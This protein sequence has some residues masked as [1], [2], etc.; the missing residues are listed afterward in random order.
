MT[1]TYAQP[2]P[3]LP[4]PATAT[5]TT[6][7]GGSTRRLTGLSI[8]L[9]CRDAESEVAGAIRSLAAGAAA[10]SAEYEIVVVDDGSRDGTAGRVAAFV[11]ATGP[12]RLLVHSHP[13]G[14]GAAL[15]TGLG[16]ARMPW[17]LLASAHEA[18]ADGD[19]PGFAALTSSAELVAGRRVSRRDRGSRRPAVAVW[20]ALMRALFHL[21]VHDVDCAFKLV[22]RDRLAGV[23][24]RASGPVVAAE[25]VIRCRAAGARVAEYP[26]VP[27]PLGAQGRLHAGAVVRALV[28]TARRQ[29][30]LRRLARDG[31]RRLAP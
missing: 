10:T 18:L 16:A 15:R 11:G 12:V 4:R 30:E 28:E 26:M 14:Y 20:N 13:R 2:E 29:A 6:R 1:V 19:L 9:P 24:L 25:L 5:A 7:S 27:L 8:V 21:P 17:V 3:A 23:E 31:D 22:S